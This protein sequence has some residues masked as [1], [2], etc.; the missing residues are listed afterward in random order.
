MSWGGGFSKGSTPARQSFP[1]NCP[2]N[3]LSQILH[4]LAIA[5]ELQ[6]SSRHGVFAFIVPSSCSD[7]SPSMAP[8]LSIP[9]PSWGTLCI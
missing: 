1:L 3:G 7:I 6:T 9:K 2:G 8:S 5:K 4:Y